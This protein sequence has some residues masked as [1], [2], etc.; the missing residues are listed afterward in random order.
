MGTMGSTRDFGPRVNLF[1][2][3]APQRA[4]ERMHPHAKLWRGI[5]HRVGQLFVLS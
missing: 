5:L 3:Q 2:A 1:A 4:H